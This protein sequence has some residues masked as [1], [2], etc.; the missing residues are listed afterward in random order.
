MTDKLWNVASLD[1]ARKLTIWDHIQDPNSGFHNDLVN[2]ICGE[3]YQIQTGLD[4]I[5][6]HDDLLEVLNYPN[7]LSAISDA[8]EQRLNNKDGQY[9]IRKDIEARIHLEERLKQGPI[10]KSDLNV[11][12]QNVS[13]NIKRDVDRLLAIAF[14]DDVIFTDSNGAHVAHLEDSSVNSPIL[15]SVWNPEVYH[16]MNE[17]TH[18]YNSE[19]N[20]SRLWD[21]WQ[22][23]KKFYFSL[24]HLSE[25]N[26]NLEVASTL[27]V[28]L[29]WILTVNPQANLNQVIA[30]D[31]FRKTMLYL[32]NSTDFKGLNE[33]A[34][35]P[36]NIYSSW[37]WVNLFKLIS[38]YLDDAGQ[39]GISNASSLIDYNIKINFLS[40]NVDLLWVQV[41]KLFTRT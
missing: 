11:N 3:E 14:N 30:L 25:N 27:W 12:L 7:L 6:S 21:I 2:I 26:Q 41:D 13:E 24:L 16:P 10:S 15:D 29:R 37:L 34:R 23:L 8:Q 20:N 33:D 4:V 36:A 31:I 9:S 5:S 35:V 38:E 28:I 18:I 40:I 17:F 32:I 22:E 39:R 1:Q 19:I